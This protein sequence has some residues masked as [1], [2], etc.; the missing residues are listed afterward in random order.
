MVLFLIVPAV[1][2]NTGLPITFSYTEPTTDA[3]GAPLDDLA[4]VEIWQKGEP[5]RLVATIPASSKHG[6]G[7]VTHDYVINLPDVDGQAILQHEYYAIAIDEHENMSEDSKSFNM[8][9]AIVTKEKTCPECEV[10]KPCEESRP[11]V[12]TRAKFVAECYC[13]GNVASCVQLEK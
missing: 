1:M 10:C 9:I 7:K 8:P 2:A 13:A 6:G 4:Y 5:D 3:K 11:C 12:P